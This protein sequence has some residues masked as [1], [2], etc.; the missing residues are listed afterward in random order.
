MPRG[1]SPFEPGSNHPRRNLRRRGLYLFATSPLPAPVV[2]KGFSPASS[3]RY[4]SQKIRDQVWL[5]DNSQCQYRNPKTG[6]VCGSEKYLEMDH[7]YPH[8]LGGEGSLEN[9]EL[10]CRGHNQWRAGVLNHFFHSFHGDLL[11]FKYLIHRSPNKFLLLLDD[12][13]RF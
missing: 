13:W 5:R 6:R 2:A 3:T 9:L 12:P 4:I 11:V 1:L 8:A 7:K 10:K